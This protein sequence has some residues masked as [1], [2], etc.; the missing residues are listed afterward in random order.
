MRNIKRLL[1][2]F[3]NIR[4]PQHRGEKIFLSTLS[5]LK[6]KKINPLNLLLTAIARLRPGVKIIT[7]IKSGRII[8]LPIYQSE[9]SAD[10]YAIRWLYKATQ[11]RNP[12]AFLIRELVDEIYDTLKEEGRAFKSKLDLIKLIRESRVNLRKRFRRFKYTKKPQPQKIDKNF[13]KSRLK[14]K[15]KSKHPS[16]NKKVVSKKK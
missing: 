16:L 4:S 11:D 10:Y 15:V 5:I 2:K 13:I 6:E 12:K 1:C 14:Y 3:K 9:Q 7:R 8:Y